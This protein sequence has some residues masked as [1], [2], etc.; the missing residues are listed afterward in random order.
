M[1]N[2]R[3]IENGYLRIGVV[4]SSEEKQTEITQAFEGLGFQ[5]VI[6]YESFAAIKEDVFLGKI[7][8][9]F[10]TLKD[11]TEASLLDLMSETYAH[12]RHLNIV[13]SALLGPNEQRHIPSAFAA[14]LFTWHPDKGV[15]EY[16]R[17]S[18]WRL[19]RK[20]GQVHGVGPLIP[21]L[22]LR[23]Y[24][25]NKAQW[26]DMVTL[27][28]R[29]V[30]HFPYEDLIKVHLIEALHCCGH[31]HEAG[32]LLK[33]M[34][35]F[36]PGLAGQIADL[37]TRLAISSHEESHRLAPRF[38]L[39]HVVIVHADHEMT[40]LLERI[41]RTYGFEHIEIC[42]HIEAAWQ[43]VRKDS[44]DL[45]IL[46][47]ECE[48]V[49]A[50]NLLQRIRLSGYWEFPILVQAHKV[51]VS[52][53]KLLSLYGVAHC[54]PKSKDE[55][56]HEMSIAWTIVQSKEPTEAQGIERKIKERL[57]RRDTPRARRFLERYISVA[58]RNTAKEKLLQ[59]HIELV[60]GNFLDAK[61]LL[62]EARNEPKSNVVA[63]DSMMAQCLFG[64]DDF[65]GALS[66]LKRI[67][68]YAVNQIEM[69]CLMARCL[70]RLGDVNAAQKVM[71]EAAGID[72]NHPWVLRTNAK[73]RLL[74]ED[75]S[76]I[77]S[78]K[79][80]IDLTSFVGDCINLAIVYCLSNQSVTRG[81]NLLKICQ[82]ISKAH[83]L[84]CLDWAE[85][86]LAIA[87]LRS[88]NFDLAKAHLDLASLK[89]HPM[90]AEKYGQL[91]VQIEAH[92]SDESRLSYEYCDPK[93]EFFDGQIEETKD[94]ST[95]DIDDVESDMIL[96]RGIFNYG[97]QAA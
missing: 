74:T 70:L 87:Y 43:R 59:A 22:F 91:L 36:E 26:A 50:S 9:V 80:K 12:H 7:Q 84:R 67:K 8:W 20:I 61:Y 48:G 96:L 68:K 54:L 81:V 47:W 32:E 78:I 52:E 44:V 75:L 60:D 66:I 97:P 57:S 11:E 35:Y 34:E 53:S 79:D 71:I 19:K 13:F 86:N 56:L 85:I 18:L 3:L 45:M 15:S 5:T 27:C 76:V 17:Q 73:I 95:Q 42:E 88:S 69:N 10:S 64:L 29:M 49:S 82:E 40:M 89:T 23:A 65:P 55:L 21:Y 72:E 39:K 77:E 31:S 51:N 38:G 46:D 58:S 93:H 6:P 25:K 4:G 30:R 28:R 83:G 14:G 94:R 1:L 90:L 24:L 41:C 62:M 63:V 37:R 2:L 16:T 33:D 92:G